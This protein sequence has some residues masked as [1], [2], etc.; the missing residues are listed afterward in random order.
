MTALGRKGIV[1]TNP[2]VKQTIQQV[3]KSIAAVL[4]VEIVIVNENFKIVGG[5]AEHQGKYQITNNS[6]FK[7]VLTTGKPIIIENPGFNELKAQH[8][9]DLS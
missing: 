4:N 7:H 2:K 5:T 1:L 9:R 8:T 6:I 3:A